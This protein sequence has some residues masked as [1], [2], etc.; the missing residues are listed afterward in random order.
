MVDSVSPEMVTVPARAHANGPSRPITVLPFA[1]VKVP[2]AIVILPKR[3][4]KVPLLVTVPPA[5]M[6]I[7]VKTLVSWPPKRSDIPILKVP[8]LFTMMPALALL[9]R[10]PLVPINNVPPFTVVVP[11]KVLAPESVSV[12]VP[13]LVK[14]P[15]PEIAPPI[16]FD[17]PLELIVRLLR[18]ETVELIVTFPAPDEIVRLVVLD[19]ECAPIE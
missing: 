9:A 18:E 10:E 4:K 5:L 16:E 12:P 2:P 19:F 11:V 8:P 7:G 6:V 15:V 1:E 17:V 14:L 13:C 3:L